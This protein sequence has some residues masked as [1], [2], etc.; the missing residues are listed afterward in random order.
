MMYVSNKLNTGEQEIRF[1]DDE[2]LQAVGTFRALVLAHNATYVCIEWVRNDGVLL[3][4][5][6][7]IE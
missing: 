4:D 5:R 7:G 6:E 1:L 2:F 3:P